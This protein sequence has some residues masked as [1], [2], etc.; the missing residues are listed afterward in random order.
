MNGDIH[1]YTLV[2]EA[3]EQGQEN[4]VCRRRDGQKLGDPLDQ[5]KQEKLFDWH[6]MIFLAGNRWKLVS[7]GL[8]KIPADFKV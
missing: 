8:T 5:G 2:L 6:G 4:Q 1:C 3:C 7:S